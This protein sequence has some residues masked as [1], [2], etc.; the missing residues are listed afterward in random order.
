MFIH[1]HYPPVRNSGIYRNYF[2]SGT[3]TDLT[4]SSDLITS[5]L[6]RVLPVEKL[7]EHTK[8]RRHEIFAPDY[9][10]IASWMGG[11]KSNKGARF[12]ETQKKS[13]TVQWL[14]R[15][16]RSFPFN[17]FLAEGGVI[18]IILGYLKACRIIRKE[19]P[20]VV[21]SSFM[22]YADHIIAF[23][24]KSTFPTLFWVADFRDLHIEPIYKN[25]IWPRFQRA[26]ERWI[27]RKADLITCVSE[28]ISQ[29]MSYYG[30]PTLT[31]TKGVQPRIR[32]APYNIFTLA[33]TGSLFL[34]YRD[35]RPLFKAI[36]SLVEE[37]Q[38]TADEI[39]F[40]YAGKDSALMKAWADDCNLGKTYVDLGLLPRNDSLDVQSASHINVLLTTASKEHQ[41]LLTGKI[42]EYFEAGNP[43]L[44]LIQG[45]R[46]MEIE[47]LFNLLNAGIVVYDDTKAINILK[48]FIYLRY[49][50]W[51]RDGKIQTTLR[52]DVLI[53]E[54]SWQNQ[55][56]KLLE[57]IH[58]TG[59]I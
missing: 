28:G 5:D 29:K 59:K 50:D 18:Y 17:V 27:L 52:E 53:H 34:H 39:R 46:D 2:L 10:R 45:E 41:G 48:D 36:S 51:K 23:L 44:C 15:V 40:V 37:G 20:T 24:V 21:L 4:G 58:A 11:K 9:R 32:I 43:V 25:T 26:V 42:F 33:Y 30:R 14:I 55:A 31:L 3:L 13:K 12:S 8:I 6:Q 38:I 57:V 35:P 56:N 49:T 54:Y 22:P 16:Q 47:K 7:A 1:Y 19:K